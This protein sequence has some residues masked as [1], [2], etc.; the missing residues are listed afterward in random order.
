MPAQPVTPARQLMQ[1]IVRWS[2]II[3]PLLAVILLWRH[4]APLL[5]LM[6]LALL[7]TS[8]VSP[9]ADWL[10]SRLGGSRLLGVLTVY[11][12]MILLL[13]GVASILGPLLIKQVNAMASEF[14]GQNLT[15]LIA[16][17]KSSILGFVPPDLQR[18]AESR[19]D[20]TVRNLPGFLASLA[21]DLAGVVL[22]VAS[23]VGKLILVLVFTFILM[24]ES[25]NFKVQFMRAVP[26]TYFEMVLNL[27]DKINGQVSGYLRGQAAAAATVGILSMIGL[28]TIS[29][30]MD[31]TIPY[32]VI[33]GM[34]A[35]FANLIPFVGPF[36]G[37][38]FAWVVYLM[39]PQAAG[40]SVTVLVALAGMFL[41]VQMIDNFFVSPKIM[42]AS[43]GMH[44]LVVIV[45]IMIGGSMMGPLGMLFAV[46]TF[47]VVK[48]TIEEV[49]WG[50][51]AY[52]IL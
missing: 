41:V 24:L 21:D 44:P 30:V 20:A 46:P 37:I 51:R 33:V 47:G 36:V 50:L 17:L 39:T 40:I 13:V 23:L 49:L 3:F 25:R 9:L 45:V 16:N 2:Q 12:T 10:E 8:I 26:N 43:V 11:V 28:F 35:G 27:L 48:V 5:L 38:F 22:Q 31:V 6:V 7:L 29:L 52:R 32:F 42:S 19:L 1:V 4:V 15:D 14:K 18:I 34:L